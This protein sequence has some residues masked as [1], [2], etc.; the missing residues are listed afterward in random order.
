MDTEWLM[1][2]K[3]NEY[4]EQ[5]DRN[6]R[7]RE[8]E[9]VSERRKR[10]CASNKHKIYAKQARKNIHHLKCFALYIYYQESKANQNKKWN[11][12]EKKEKS[13]KLLCRS[14]NSFK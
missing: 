13:I 9:R 6:K 4:S 14:V 1:N 12:E 5:M 10:D 7:E 11:V 2:V 8:R 3:K